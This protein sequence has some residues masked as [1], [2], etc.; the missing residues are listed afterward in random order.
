VAITPRKKYF[1]RKLLKG[2][3]FDEVDQKKFLEKIL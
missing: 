2:K 1:G 3:L